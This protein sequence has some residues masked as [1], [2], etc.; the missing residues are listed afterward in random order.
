MKRWLCPLVSRNARNGQTNCLFL[1][2][3]PP[4]I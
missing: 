2:F 3:S 4:Y 1:S